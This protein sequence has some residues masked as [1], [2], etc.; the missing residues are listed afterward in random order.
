MVPVKSSIPS[1]LYRFFTLPL[2]FIIDN[3][4]FSTV[5]IPAESYPLYSSLKRP[6]SNI[7]LAFLCPMYPII[8]HISRTSL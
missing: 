8:P 5:E 3:P 7:G 4:F 1:K 2:S 6:L